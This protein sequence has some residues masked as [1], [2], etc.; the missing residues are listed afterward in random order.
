M[1]DVQFSN[2]FLS[3]HSV[4]SHC[5]VL[6]SCCFKWDPLKHIQMYLIIQGRSAEEFRT[7]LD[8]G[9]CA[10]IFFCMSINLIVVCANRG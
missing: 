10:A 9:V 2:A 3:Q 8:I 6:H 5:S 1:E 4:V 7:H